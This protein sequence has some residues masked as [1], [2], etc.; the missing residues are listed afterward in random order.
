MEFWQQWQFVVLPE[1]HTQDGAQH[2]T[3]TIHYRFCLDTD[4]NELHFRQLRLRGRIGL[5]TVSVRETLMQ[6]PIECDEL[7]LFVFRR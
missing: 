6:D 7:S 5:K 3:E 1:G 4:V 2:S